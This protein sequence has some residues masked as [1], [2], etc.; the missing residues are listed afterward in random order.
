MYAATER[1]CLPLY[2][3]FGLTIAGIGT[4]PPNSRT[5]NKIFWTWLNSRKVSRRVNFRIPHSILDDTH[6]RLV[7][8]W[9]DDLP[10]DPS[11]LTQLRASLFALQH[12]HVQHITIEAALYGGLTKRFRQKLEFIL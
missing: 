10:R 3:G 7:G 9:R 2:K 12:M 1:T 8:L 6:D 11:D 4:A 5:H